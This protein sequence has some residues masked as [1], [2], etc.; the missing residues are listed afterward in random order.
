MS[1]EDEELTSSIES[2]I[3]DLKDVEGNHKIGVS[4]HPETQRTTNGE[5]AILVMGVTGSGKSTFISRLTEENVEIG[6]SLESCTTEVAGYIIRSS[7]GQKINLIDTPGFDDTQRSNV[8]L[9]QNL[10]SALGA[11]YANDDIHFAGIIY[12]HRITDQRVAG[13]SLKSLRIFEKICG[14]EN[15]PNTVLLTTMWNLMESESEKAIGYDRERTL[16]EKGEFFG[17]MVQGGAHMMRDEGD[18]VSAVDV[19]EHIV[20]RQHRVVT[21]LQ[22]EIVE[23]EKQL[24]ETAVGIYLCGELEQ[25]RKRFETERDEL[26]EAL[27]E[28]IRD[29]DDDLVST[30]SDQKKDYNERI[31][32]TDLEQKN[33]L[34]SFDEMARHQTEWCERVI[35]EAERRRQEL[36]EK[37]RQIQDLQEQ[38]HR[39]EMD[40]MRE[41]NRLKRD[42]KGRPSASEKEHAAKLERKRK[43]LK[44]TLKE[45]ESDR[46]SKEKEMKQFKPQEVI[47]KLVKWWLAAEPAQ[48]G[49]ANFRRTQPIPFFGASDRAKRK[50]LAK[51]K[52]R[53]NK[54]RQV[55]YSWEEDTSPDVGVN[56]NGANP[57]PET[58]TFADQTPYHSH[59]TENWSTELH[60]SE[61]L[62]STSLA[63]VSTGDTAHYFYRV[64]DSASETLHQDSQ[65][66]FVYPLTAAGS[67]TTSISFSNLPRRVPEPP[68]VPRVYSPSSRQQ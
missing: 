61:D 24:G 22:R 35:E 51:L 53:K 46:N 5:L 26:E 42:A 62:E 15:Y 68:V 54:E 60:S 21:A 12:L 8:Q 59:H 33:L 56:Y 66:A 49:G 64:P 10:A 58:H 57:A 52:R 13:S 38:L 11:M 63:Q 6:H 19:I 45:K 1:S 43:D 37:E 16:A 67:S 29:K 7:S 48:K 50:P 27:E 18:R 31:R 17:A 32:R 47:S 44:A 25:A 40:H 41:M 4:R 28:A 14:E 30:I 36:E 34:I 20:R 3:S 2:S 39:T 9:L 23:E 65:P 55:S